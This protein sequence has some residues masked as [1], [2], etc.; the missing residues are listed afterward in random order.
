MQYSGQSNLADAA[1][2]TQLAAAAETPSHG[3]THMSPYGA[4]D[5]QGAY[6]HPGPSTYHH[7]DLSEQQHQHQHGAAPVQLPPFSS[8]D[9]SWNQFLLHLQAQ[10]DQPA[11]LHRSTSDPGIS[12]FPSYPPGSGSAGPF[13]PPSPTETRQTRR[14]SVSNAGPSHQDSEQTEAEHLNISEEKRS[15]NTAASGKLIYLL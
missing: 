7:H 3:V 13:F 9:S 12:L 1:L 5:F 14:A 11:S 6:S 15:R 4:M 10:Q 8:I 2:L